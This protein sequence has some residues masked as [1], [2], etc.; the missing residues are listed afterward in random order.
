MRKGR[1]LTYLLNTRQSKFT[2][3]LMSSTMED[4]KQG[5]FLMATS[6]ENLL[7]QFTQEWFLSETTGSPYSWLNSTVLN[8]GELTL[9]MDTWRHTQI[10]TFALLLFLSL[11]NSKDTFY[12]STKRCMGPDQMVPSGMTDFLMY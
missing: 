4:T 10:R 3:V 5:L 6:P 11:E 12:S 2:L 9:E 7:R 1:L 8:S